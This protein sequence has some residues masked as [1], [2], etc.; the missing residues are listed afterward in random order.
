MD[1]LLAKALSSLTSAHK[2]ELRTLKISDQLR[3][4][5]KSGRVKPTPAQAAI[6]EQ[7]A[8]L[9][10]HS[11]RNWLMLEKA[12][13]E[14]KAWLSKHMGKLKRGAGVTLSYGA[15][16]AVGFAVWADRLST[17]YRVQRG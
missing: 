7:M 4:D 12:T 8:G 14:Q 16:V 1:D 6:L 15:A 3:H 10:E 17:M 9:P 5:W 13:P 2:A 11:L